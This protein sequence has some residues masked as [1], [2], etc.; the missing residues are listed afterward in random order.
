MAH[1]AAPHRKVAPAAVMVVG[2]GC[3]LVHLAAAARF[4]SRSRR[5]R[6]AVARKAMSERP[7]DVPELV[8]NFV[9]RAAPQIKRAT[10]VYLRQHGEIRLGA[11]SPWKSLEAEQVIRIPEPGFVWLARMKMAGFVKADILDAYSD[12]DGFLEARLFGSFPMARAAG[13]EISRGELMRY[14][15]ELAWA[16]QAMLYNRHLSW[17]EIDANTVEVSAASRGSPV[18]VRLSFADGDLI[19][20]AADDRPRLVDNFAIR[21]PWCGRFFD[22]REIG[23]WRI[24]SRA[25]ATW[26]LPEAPFDYFRGEIVALR[27]D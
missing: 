12:G 14:L 18:R 11:D 17:R 24:P 27:V 8:R 21:T 1:S 22:Y 9:C 10:T 5:L 20:V 4:R 19:G 7:L 15:A 13:P 23:G 26:V 3:V 16:P 2:T 6:K 25:I